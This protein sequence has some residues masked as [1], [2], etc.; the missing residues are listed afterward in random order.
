M[1]QKQLSFLLDVIHSESIQNQ[2]RK[3][4]YNKVGFD[5]E[6]IKFIMDEFLSIMLLKNMIFLEQKKLG[7]S[8]QDNIKFIW[9]MTIG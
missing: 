9:L 3:K 7:M 6:L 4:N 5:L 2:W 8:K 1:R